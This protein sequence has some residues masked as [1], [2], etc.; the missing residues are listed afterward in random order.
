VS[1]AR[2]LLA[3]AE[4]R[5]EAE[6]LVDGP[7]RRRA[8]ELVE[9]VQAVAGGLAELGVGPGDRV[10]VC[11]RN[12]LE[13][14]LLSW[15]TWWLGACLAPVNWR[16]PP[17]V[18]G[19]LAADAEARVFAACDAG[20]PS[21]RALE[22]RLPLVALD[23]AA[24]GL[25]LAQLRLAAGPAEPVGVDD[26]APALLLYT[27]GTTGLPKGVIRSHR[28]EWLA[29]LAHVIQTRMVP[30][31]RTL[32][33]MP[34][35]H[36]MGQRSLLATVALDG[37]LVVQRSFDPATTLALVA[38]ERIGALYLAP[39]LYHDLVVEA[40]RQDR[41]LPVPRLAAAGAPLS[42]SLVRRLVDRFAPEVVV[43]HYGSSEVY[44]V[45]IGPDQVAK[46]GSAGRAGL[47]ARIRLVEPREDAQPEDLVS[48]GH[49]GLILVGLD[50][51][52]AFDG[53]WRRPDADQRS[54]RDGWYV[55]GD[56][57]RV[58][59]DGDL[60]IVG[61]LDDMIVTG[62]ENVHPT[63]VEEV[64]L[65]HPKVQ[66]AAV[67]GLPDERLGQVVTACLVA[68]GED[69]EALA[70]EL[71][72]YCRASPTLAGFQRPRRFVVLDDVPRTASG[73]LQ[74]AEL[75]RLLLEGPA[76]TPGGSAT[77]PS[78]EEAT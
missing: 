64:L 65:G 26:R 60:W 29:A 44:T 69:P 21:A 50:S 30:G 62:G 34:W 42:P 57:G 32:G 71:D 74:R 1:L 46:P 31:E 68:P 16:L 45:S 52:E 40:E 23:E 51:P 27:S 73:K 14:W 67:V 3:A 2:Q 38:E 8:G 56:L 70:A 18:V 6:A 11:A 77:T 12:R 7:E 20:A 49:T 35:C 61:R 37:C 58:D 78:S 24:P 47:H 53:Y 33:V 9:G 17:A 63:E 10:M 66:A 43:N 19:Q 55:T 59:E 15:A 39:T 25:P 54:R 5:P 28:A 4:R 13:T 22:G 76:T 36:T 48:P 75:R 72:A 41:R